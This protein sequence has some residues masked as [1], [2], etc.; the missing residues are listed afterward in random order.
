MHPTLSENPVP[1]VLKVKSDNYKSFW[2]S[3]SQCDDLSES[4]S[5]GGWPALC[6]AQ[7]QFTII[8]LR[9]N[10]TTNM[11]SGA[12][13]FSF[14]A[15]LIAFDAIDI[16]RKLT[17]CWSISVWGFFFLL[18]P[19]PAIWP[20][21]KTNPSSC[22][23]VCLRAVVSVCRAKSGVKCI[24]EREILHIAMVLGIDAPSSNR[25]Q[26]KTTSGFFVVV[27][28][29][30][31]FTSRFPFAGKEHELCSRNDGFGWAS[32]ISLL[33]EQPLED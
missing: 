13:P 5:N 12:S 27:W 7:S 19:R 11:G 31:R 24:R 1:K 29:E 32:N 26:T 28:Y 21:H 20:N 25:N 10:S 17:C 2:V 22:D 4:K 30:K 9:C 3:F 6:G 33:L 14:V 15:I 8:V 18:V 16:Y 23:G